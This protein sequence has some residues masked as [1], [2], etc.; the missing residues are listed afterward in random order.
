MTARQ[1]QRRRSA[2]LRNSPMHA[3]YRARVKEFMAQS[4]EVVVGALTSRSALEFR[5]NERQQVRAWKDEVQ[6]LRSAFAQIPRAQKWSLILEYSMRRLERRPDAVILAPGVIIVIEFKMGAKSHDK[7]Q[8][9]QVEDYALCIRDFHGASRDFIIVPIVCAEHAAHTDSMRPS[10]VDRVA[11]TILT[12][13]RDLPSALRLAAALMQVAR[14]LTGQAF[15]SG[16]YS[17]TPT[18]VEAVREIYRTHSVAAIWRTDAEGAALLQTA[19]RLRYWVLQARQRKEHI[20]CVVTGTPGAGKSLLGLDLILAESV[21][22]VAGEAAAMLTGNRPLVHVLKRALAADANSRGGAGGVDRALDGALQT[23]LGYLRQHAD[24]KAEAPP[25]RVIVFDEAQRAWDAATGQELLQRRRSEPALFLE[26]LQRLPWACLVCLVGPGQEINRGEGGMRL[27]DDALKEEAAAG[28]PWRVVAATSS[29]VKRPLRSEVDPTMHLPSSVRAFRNPRYTQWVDTLLSGQIAEAARIATDMLIPPAFLTRD[30]SELK[31]WL[32]LRRRGGRR[33]GLLM[34]SG[35][36]RLAAEGIHP[37]PHSSEL[38]KIEC[39]FLKS[40]PDFRSSDSLEVPLSE[41]GCQGLELDY[42]GLC[43]GGDLLWSPTQLRWLP[44]KMKSPRWQA[45]RK[46]E[47]AQF[48]MNAYRV[49]LTRAREG[50]CIYVPQGSAEDT[51]RLSSEFDD[52][53]QT[54]LQAG[55]PA[56]NL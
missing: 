46:L 12:N 26:I 19:R 11:S 33:I 41:F 54:L 49:L 17:P 5:G 2:A 52:L 9:E 29:S 55:I 20:L 51:T 30:L 36:V 27:W 44:R 42:V 10:V 14:S 47:A 8:C 21:G 38:S 4:P 32:T 25:E 28:H 1:P 53:A 6:L 7:S 3:Y 48:R 16:H 34:S 15:D 35:A 23:L 56:A 39:W 45:I 22:R 50:L 31:Q 24:E 40:L 43:W 37:P 18:I 13:A